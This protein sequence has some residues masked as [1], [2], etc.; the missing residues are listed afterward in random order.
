MMR[1]LVMLQWG[2]AHV[3]AETNTCAT[4]GQT[5][6]PLQWGRAHVS[7]ETTEGVFLCRFAIRFNGAALT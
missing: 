7:A 4:C 1:N 2:R 6:L 3:S 5:E